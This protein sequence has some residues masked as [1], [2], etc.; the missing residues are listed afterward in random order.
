MVLNYLPPLQDAQPHDVLPRYAR[1]AAPAIT[2][3]HWMRAAL[4]VHTLLQTRGEPDRRL[5]SDDLAI[6]WCPFSDLYH[7]DQRLAEVLSDPG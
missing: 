2:K 3:A 6:R 7:Q 5:V 1:P 4:D